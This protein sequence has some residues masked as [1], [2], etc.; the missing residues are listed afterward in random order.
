[1]LPEA[2]LR[3][4]KLSAATAGLAAAVVAGRLPAAEQ[5]AKP[6][7]P[8]QE[9]KAGSKEE[10]KKDESLSEEARK[11]ID[12]LIVK[13]GAE[14]FDTRDGSQKELVKLGKADAKV[15]PYLKEASAKQEDEEIKSR[16]AAVLKELDP[17][18]TP[19]EPER[20][21]VDPCPM[22]GRG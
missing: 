12:A 13:L 6:Q 18:A 9:R 8:K 1:M 14:D 17:N 5:P 21:W 3:K 7:P 10:G 11:N 2:I 22:C 19:Q 20:A 15:P 16:I 4:M